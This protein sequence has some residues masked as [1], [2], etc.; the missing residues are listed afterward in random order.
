M[1]FLMTAAGQQEQGQAQAQADRY[2]AGIA[3]I[4]E[5]IAKQNAS[6]AGAAGEE[7]AGISEMRTRAQ[8]G[9]IKAGQ[10]AKGVDV[11]SGSAVDVQAS[12]AAIGKLDAMTIRSNAAREAY[13]Y[14]T[15]A[16]NQEAQQKLDEYAASQDI[17]AGNI[18]SEGT[19]LTGIVNTGFQI[20]SFAQGGGFG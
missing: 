7:Q 5:Q 20:A 11:N 6:Y 10:A 9:S 12:E 17:E 18:A 1:G 13:G 15:Q 16:V 3:Q 2:N 19:L 8:E 4:N 14:Q